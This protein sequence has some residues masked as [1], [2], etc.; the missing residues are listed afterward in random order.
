MEEKKQEPVHFNIIFRRLFSFMKPY[1]KGLIVSLI[2]IIFASIFNSFGPFVLG[3]ATDALT[4]LVIGGERVTEAIRSFITTLIVLGCIYI[5]YAVLKYISICI[6][7][8]VS[9]KTIYD[10]RRDVD[11]KFKK[12]PL[13]YFDTNT[14]GD[15]LSRITND[16]DTISNSLQQSLDQIVTSITSVICIFA[17][18]LFISPILTF[19]GIITIPLALFFSM[20]IAS[21]SQKYFKEQQEVLGNMNG[22]VE[23]MYTGHNIVSAYGTEEETIQRFEGTNKTLY[24]SG[25]KSQFLSST[26][27]PITQGMTNLGY[28]AVVVVSGVLVINGKMSIGMIQSFIQY[29]RQF[30]QPINQTVQIANVL[31]STAA[32]AT[33]VFEFLD[34]KEEIADITE[35]QKPELIDGSIIFEHVKFGY[36]PHRMLMQDVNLK[37]KPGDKVAI[38][39]PTGAGKTTLINLLLRFYDIN[40]GTI[41]VSG[42]DIRKMKRTE[43]RETF[44]IVLQDSWL[45]TGSIMENIRYGRLDATDEN[46]ID[47]AKA[48]RADHFIQALPDGYNFMLQEGA[49]NLAQGERQLLT[50]ARAILSNS[51]IMILDEATSSVDTR[52]EVLIQ[53]AMKTLMKGRTSFVIAHRLSTI[54]DADMIIYMENGDIKETGNHNDLMKADGLYAKLYNSQFANANG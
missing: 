51:P 15:I 2:F 29:L 8:K 22:Y 42:V 47:A 36:V 13:N 28:V 20:K 31:Q 18:M 4:G 19:I 26:L 25:W 14:Y 50:I 10:L 12:L 3:K 9:Q 46:V 38:V 34:E 7:V 35:S 49:M 27:M 24:D 30:S 41:Y 17:M 6:L 53:D 48:A 33:R 52:T 5:L 21:A 44:G 43:L 45:F 11:R 32:A 39:G 54:K 37:V 40:S 16:V 23:E 1:R